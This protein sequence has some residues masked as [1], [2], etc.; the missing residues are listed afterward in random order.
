MLFFKNYIFPNNTSNTFTIFKSS[1]Q[2]LYPYIIYLH[3]VFIEQLEISVVLTF[4]CDEKDRNA[5]C[6][7]FSN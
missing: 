6:G 3:Q 7:R 4:E 1:E 5:K 2:H